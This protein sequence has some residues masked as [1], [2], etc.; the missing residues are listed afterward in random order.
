MRLARAAGSFIL[1]WIRY[2]PGFRGCHLCVQK[3]QL[4]PTLG[5]ISSTEPYSSCGLNRMSRPLAALDPPHRMPTTRY[6]FL[7]LMSHFSTLIGMAAYSIRAGLYS[8]ARI[9]TPG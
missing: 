5:R 9:G 7:S 6:F 1:S 8:F 2:L 4:S 3:L